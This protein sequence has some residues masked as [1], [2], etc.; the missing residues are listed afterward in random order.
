MTLTVEPSALL[1]YARQLDRATNDAAA[2]RGYVGR[3]AAAG[4]GGELYSLAREGHDHAVDVLTTTLARLTTLLEA[5][6]PEVSGA[7]GYYRQTDRA[8]AT[9]VDRTLATGFGQCPT[10]LE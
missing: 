7:A 3:F 8:A 4:T 9:A 5:S 2:I 10:A 1:D 6:G